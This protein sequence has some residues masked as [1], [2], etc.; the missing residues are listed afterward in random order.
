MQHYTTKKMSDFLPYLTS[1]E[2]VDLY[3]KRSVLC[4]KVDESMLD[5]EIILNGW[6]QNKR[7]SHESLQFL[8]LRDESGS[9]P[10]IFQNESQDNVLKEIEKLSIESVITVVGKVV[11]KPNNKLGEKGLE[12]KILDLKCLNLAKN[13]PFLPSFEKEMPNEEVRLKYRYLDLRRPSLLKNLQLRSQCSHLIRSHLLSSGFTE[14]ETP[15][16]FKPTVEGAKEF[17]I[18]T[19]RKNYYYSLPQSP[20]QYKQLLIASGVDKYFQ[21][22]KC[23]RDEDLRA[24]RQPEFTQIDLELAYATQKEIMKLINQMIKKLF[25][26]ILNVKIKE[27]IE[28]MSYYNAMLHYGSDKPDRRYGFKIQNLLKKKEFFCNVLILKEDKDKKLFNN[29]IINQFKNDIEQ[30]DTTSKTQVYFLKVKKE[31]SIINQIEKLELPYLMENGIEKKQIIEKIESIQN[32]LS[33]GDILCIEFRNEKYQGG[34]SKLGKLRLAYIQLLIDH[35]VLKFNPNQFELL[36]VNEFPLLQKEVNENG[37]ITHF[38]PVHHPFTAPVKEDFHLLF[39]NPELVK[40]Q[41]YDLVING[42]EI[43]GGSIRIHDPEVQAFLLKQV[44]KVLEFILF[45]QVLFYFIL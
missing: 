45:Y 19:R 2:A 17:L 20:Q 40:A 8:T 42:I 24:D 6:V 22:A 13:L 29:K 38:S 43:G 10:L 12:I 1:C 37:Q 32:Q 14:V 5:K 30:V 27:E 23:F 33:I 21:I 15:L 18:P 36:W 28:V 31:N 7:K 39:E 34:F 35:N 16:L 25:Q 26:Q 4:N 11:K 41:H 9:I 3:S 44:M